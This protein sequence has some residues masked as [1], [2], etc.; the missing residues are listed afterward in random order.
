MFKFNKHLLPVLAVLLML[1]LIPTAFA[2]DID[3]VGAV[4]VNDQSAVDSVSQPNDD[5]AVESV[6]QSAAVDDEKMSISDDLEVLSADNGFTSTPTPAVVENYNGSSE[7]ITVDISTN[8]MTN[9]PADLQNYYGGVYVFIDHNDGSDVQSIKIKSGHLTGNYQAMGVYSATVTLDLS[10][11]YNNLTNG[12]NILTFGLQPGFFNN[13]NYEY[14]YNPL[15]VIVGSGEQ[16][17]PDVIY[18]DGFDVEKDNGLGSENFPFHSLKNVLSSSNYV[19]KE[20]RLLPGT[21][22]FAENIN[23]YDRD[24]TLTAIGEVNFTST[25]ALFNKNPLGDLTFNGINFVNIASSTSAVLLSESTYLA[26]G[27]GTINFNNCS[28]IANTAENLILSSCNVNIKGCTFID[29]EATSTSIQDGGLIENHYTD[30]STIDIS[31]SIF[32]NNKIAE[33]KDV[34]NNVYGNPII[35]DAN[36]GYTIITPTAPDMEVNH[37]QDITINFTKSDGSAL[38]DYMPDLNVTLAPTSN[39]KAIPITI[40]KNSG[41]GEYEAKV[42]ANPEIIDVKVNNFVLNTFTFVVGGTTNLIDANLNVTDSLSVNVTKNATISVSRDGD[43]NI[44]FRSDDESI[45]TVDA[46]GVVT[47]V[48]VGSTTI[49]VYLAATNVYL[50]DSKKIN[51]TVT[52]LDPNV[53]V[54]PESLTIDFEKSASISVSRDGN[55]AISF[56]SDDESIAY[57]ADFGGY[58]TYYDVYGRSSGN[59]MI[60]VNVAASGNYAAGSKKINVTVKEPPVYASVYYVDFSISQDGNG[61]NGSTFKTIEAAVSA[62]NEHF[63]KKDTGTIIIK[64]G[65]YTVSSTMNI[66]RNME[67]KAEEGADVVITSNFGGSL[68]EQTDKLSV[69]LTGL[70]F[71]D[72]IITDSDAAIYYI[73]HATYDGV[74]NVLNCSFINNTAPT[75]VRLYRTSATFKYDSFIQNNVTARDS[76][77]GLINIAL[78][79]TP[80]E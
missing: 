56:A 1:V 16:P 50:P 23:L 80:Y 75:L 27:I 31:Y 69:N 19:G 34:S 35:V 59:V 45:V 58:S 64:E 33:V 40:T 26:N 41:K 8:A 3:D 22:N 70:I 57:V 39:F 63:N 47:G 12:T 15:T 38:N 4:G 44:S 68:F 37:T 51:V 72:I 46:N 18:V 32:I 21:Y 53:S 77:G 61:T 66:E 9:C 71:R 7:Q 11:I 13:K 17:D 24:F 43:G 6:E 78:A 36:N 74:L 62:A 49:T 2:E 30:S 5:V 54:N 20:I 48:S 55:G 65:N 42:P 67:I 28:F 29:N 79:G 25:R 73:G 10:T 60:T 14:T 52:L 76:T